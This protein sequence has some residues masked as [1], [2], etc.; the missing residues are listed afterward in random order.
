MSDDDDGR[1]VGRG[2]T[3][4]PQA[5]QYVRASTC[6]HARTDRQTP[7]HSTL[8]L[9]TQQRLRL[10][11]TAFSHLP[12][13]RQ[14]SCGTV[15]AVP[16]RCAKNGVNRQ[17]SLWPGSQPSPHQCSSSSSSSSSSKNNNNNNNNNNNHTHAPRGKHNEVAQHTCALAWQP[18]NTPSQAYQSSEQAGN[19][20]GRQ[21]DRQAGRRASQAARQTGGRAGRQQGRTLRHDSHH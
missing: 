14:Q 2:V 5:H 3:F 1:V 19:H 9:Q 20:R 17:R 12:L 6:V 7:L 13:R 4:H 21:A 10:R 15:G 8:A 16:G 18:V 11:T